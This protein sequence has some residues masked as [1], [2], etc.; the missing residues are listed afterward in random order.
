LVGQYLSLL[1][2][3]SVSF[4]LDDSLQFQ[5]EVFGNDPAWQKYSNDGYFFAVQR[6]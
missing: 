1:F 5:L 4:V 3:Y 6:F 2:N